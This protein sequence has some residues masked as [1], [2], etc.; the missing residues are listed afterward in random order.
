MIPRLHS[1]GRGVAGLAAYTLHDKPVVVDGETEYPVTSE[2]VAW[3]E[4]VGLPGVK[5]ELMV[6]VMQGTVADAPVL[7]E[8]AGVSARGRKL[9]APYGHMSLNWG[10][11]EQPT[12][13]EMVGAAREALS[14]I[15]ITKKH[16]ALIV[17][18]NDT[19]H[20]HVHVVFCR[21]DPETGKVAKLSHSG[22]RLSAWAEKWERKHG[23]IRIENRVAR[24]K[25]REHNKRV[26][27]EAQRA[28]CAVDPA[29]LE[30][31]PPMAPARTRDPHGHSV[32]RTPDER[33]D[34]TSLSAHHRAENT[35][36]AQ[37]KTERLELAMCHLE[38][39]TTKLEN[40]TAVRPVVES[41]RPRPMAVRPAVPEPELVT[42]EHELAQP[43]PVVMPSRPA[44]PEP[45]LRTPEHVLEPPPPV[46]MPSR[47]EVAEPVLRPAGLEPP[48]PVVM[49][50]PPERACPD[51]ELPRH[52][53]EP[54]PVQVLGRPDP[55]LSVPITSEP[56]PTP[57]PAV[58]VAQAVEARL[59]RTEP[60]PG[61]ASHRPPAVSDERFTHLVDATDDEYVRTVIAEVQRR[62]QYYSDNQREESEK[63]YLRRA[64][65]GKHEENLA[66]YKKAEAERGLFTRRSAKPTFAEAE[67]AAIREFEG[68]LL[69]IIEAACRDAQRQSPERAP[70]HG[71]RPKEA[72]R[73]KGRPVG[74]GMPAPPQREKNYGPAH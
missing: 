35:P 45:V 26:I 10:P 39:R 34:W 8:R 28:G 46:V 16:Y 64:I 49:P 69:G 57:L 48:P 52:I 65:A 5:P 73:G 19:E 25:V 18:H 24:R 11:T 44:V 74:G 61:N 15:G 29:A 43:P 72:V 47:P 53:R 55:V 37:R 14:K 68:E 71:A 7:K 50:S 32:Q 42:G 17:A 9:A 2:R 66:A 62:Q 20:P 6:R 23:K 58:H 67:A 3:T 22:T 1:N 31:M 40:E 33:Q 13:E 30:K 70:E 51:L 21:V 27:E 56:P 60:Y 38:E 54:A 63:T 41:P 12:R 36:N 4:S 59:P